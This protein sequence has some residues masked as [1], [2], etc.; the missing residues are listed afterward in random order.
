VTDDGTNDPG[1]LGNDEWIDVDID[2]DVDVDIDAVLFSA[3]TSVRLLFWVAHRWEGT[4]SKMFIMGQVAESIKRMG[5][6]RRRWL[7][8]CP[9][10]LMQSSSIPVPN[11]E[12]L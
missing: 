7:T 2:I 1:I 4:K 12:I 8:V 10:R 5:A 9:L 11:P 3:S 6:L